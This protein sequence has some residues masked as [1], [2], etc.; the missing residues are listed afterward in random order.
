MQKTSFFQ[1]VREEFLRATLFFV[2]FFILFLATFATITSASTTGGL[3][4]DILNRILASSDFAN[5]GDGTVKNA[6]KLGGEIASTYQKISAPNQSC[7]TNQC[8]YGF[9]VS[10]NILCR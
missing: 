4:G 1:I 9:D 2:S 7:G 5:P 8:I 6:E 10:G 3:F